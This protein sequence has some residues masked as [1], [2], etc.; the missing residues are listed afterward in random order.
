MNED[1][2]NLGSL[3]L[4]VLDEAD[5]MMSSA[6]DKD[7]KLVSLINF[8]IFDGMIQG[9]AGFSIHNALSLVRKS[10]RVLRNERLG[11]LLHSPV[12]ITVTTFFISNRGLTIRI[13]S[14]LRQISKVEMGIFNTRT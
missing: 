8:F 3:D 10:E 5:K 1:W 7:V 9:F 14:G 6:F 12:M 4:F 2:L 11:N 13:S